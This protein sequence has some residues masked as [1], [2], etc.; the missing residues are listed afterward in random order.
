MPVVITEDMKRVRKQLWLIE[1][2]LLDGIIDPITLRQPL[3][4]IL[5]HRTPTVCVCGHIWSDHYLAGKHSEPCSYGM[6]SC[7]QLVP[8]DAPPAP[9]PNFA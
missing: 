6:C 8:A 1:E 5:E 7:L 3:Q 2:Q 4:T 9:S